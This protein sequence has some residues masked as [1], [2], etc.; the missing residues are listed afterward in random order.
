MLPQLLG[1]GNVETRQ[2]IRSFLLDRKASNAS[3]HTI[4]WYR[5]KL[6][7]LRT[8]YPEVPEAPEPLRELLLDQTCGD[9]TTHGYYRTLRALYNFLE[10]EFGFPLDSDEKS[11]FANPIRKVR[12]PRV[13]RKVM[14]SLTLSELHQLL[15]GRNGDR[16]YKWYLR[17]HAIVTLLADTGIRAGEALLVW[18][19]VGE[20][21]VFVSGKTGEREVPILPET[22]ELLRRLKRYND[23]AF[24]PSPHVFLGKKGCLTAQGI[25]KVVKRAF[26]RAGLSAPRSS[27][28]TL[29][30]TFGRNWVA[31][32]G[33]SSVLQDIFGHS[34]PAMVR[35]YVAL[36]VKERVL[37]HRRYSPVRTQARVAQRPLWQEIEAVA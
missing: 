30:H 1:G 22:R 2:A 12:P 18:D 6:E 10:R 26:C 9:E 7:R 17:D 3:P 21:T 33:S 31:E 23:A 11:P 32:G 19:D 16:E 34:T 35:R 4:R 15:N 20:D 37:Q 29:R 28:H 27:P 13:K 5:E 36:N 8:R 25:Y 24:G 14:R